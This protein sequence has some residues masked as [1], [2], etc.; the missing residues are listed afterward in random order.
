MIEKDKIKLLAFD[1]DDTLWDCQSHFDAVEKEYQSILSDYG[2][3]TEISSRLFETE[4]ANMPLLGYGCKAFV[5]S[6]I[7]N[8]ISISNGELSANKIGQILNCGKKLSNMPAT[9]L[10]GVRCVLE[11]LNN[12]QRKYKMV[13]FT[14]GELLDQENKLRRSG[15]QSFFDATIVVSDKTSDEY[16]Y[17]C[18]RFNCSV[19]ELVMVGN[20]FRSDIA[21]VLELGGNAIYVPSKTLWQHEYIDE[22]DHTNLVTVS[23]ISDI[24]QYL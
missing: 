2:T 7:E 21:P 8:A 6:L 11:T 19:N 17:L 12:V 3:A 5:L 22:Y 14:K 20:S 10:Q 9:P 18:K 23:E 24:L 16:E 13:V 15:L 1:A 4:T